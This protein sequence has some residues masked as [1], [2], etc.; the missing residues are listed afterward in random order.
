MS[1]VDFG[2]GTESQLLSGVIDLG[3]GTVEEENPLFRIIFNPSQISGSP[4]EQRTVNIIVE[5]QGNAEGTVEL[6][7]KDHNGNIVASH[8][9]TI[10]AGQSYTFNLTITLPSQA[11]TYAW[12]IEA[13][14]VD[15]GSVDDFKTFT[16]Q[17]STTTTKKKTGFTWLPVIILITSAGIYVYVN[18]GK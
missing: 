10:P 1:A 5:N 11:G 9:Q 2:T 17:V 6:R 7:I 15:T 8:Q 18:R 4:G 13:Y 12:T 16:V 14:N 3:L